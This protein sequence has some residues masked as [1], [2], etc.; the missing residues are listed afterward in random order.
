MIDTTAR[1]RLVAVALALGAALL[2]ACGD[3]RGSGTAAATD[4]AD[5]E[6]KITVAGDSISVGLGASLRAVVD[7]STVVK[8][9]G[10]EGSG[11][12]RPDTF[13]WPARL[14]ELARDFP[15]EVLVLSLGSN[16]GQDLADGEGEPVAA[17]DD[18]QAW[19]EAY[20]A[21]LDAAVAP[22][23]ETGTTVVWVGHVRAADQV[24][25]DTNRRVHE[26]AVEV[27]AE[28]EHVE[29]ADLADLLGTG[30]DEVATRCLEPDGLHLSVDCLDEAAAALVDELPSP[31][32]P[33]QGSA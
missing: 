18:D 20:R 2:P 11:L 7:E 19:D 3:D 24:V 16:D 13:D 22:F 25:A 28:H 12:A 30:D 32:Q 9:I 8:V 4:V 33:G 17:L 21:R 31:G 14:A 23:A 15:P 26:L 10:V 6:H 27:A 5:A 29:V 1:R